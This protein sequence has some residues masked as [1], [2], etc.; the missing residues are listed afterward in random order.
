MPVLYG[1]NES[2]RNLGVCHGDDLFA[3]FKVKGIDQAD[4]DL[5][6][7]LKMVRLWV[8]FAKGESPSEKWDSLVKGKNPNFALLDGDELRMADLKTFKSFD[9]RLA[10][11]TS[12]LQ[13]LR[14]ARKDGRRTDKD[15]AKRDEL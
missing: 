4:E 7:T 12:H 6:V 1:Y 5:A 2:G 10:P 13:H 9:L 14:H 11:V 3:M 8:N 15:Q